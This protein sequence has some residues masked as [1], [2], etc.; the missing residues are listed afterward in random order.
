GALPATALPAYM[1]LGTM[2]GGSRC[3][4]CGKSSDTF[5]R[6]RTERFVHPIIDTKQRSH[7]TW[8]FTSD[9]PIAR[10]II[11]IIGTS[12]CR[13]SRHFVEEYQHREKSI[14]NRMDDD[15]RE[16][17]FGRRAHDGKGQAQQ[18]KPGYR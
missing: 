14:I 3:G 8:S 18:C 10:L 1:N 15:A 12:G 4:T 11:L 6:S 2:I 7:D 16:N 9:T 17:R 13:D 5:K